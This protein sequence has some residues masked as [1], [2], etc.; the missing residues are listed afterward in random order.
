MPASQ[1]L[2]VITSSLLW[3]KSPHNMATRRHAHIAGVTSPRVLINVADFC[4]GNFVI[5]IFYRMTQRVQVRYR[6]HRL[7][8]VFLVYWWTA[9]SVIK[10]LARFPNNLTRL[11]FRIC[12]I[13]CM[14]ICIVF[15]HGYFSHVQ[16][17]I[18]KNWKR[19]GGGRQCISPVVIFCKCTQRTMYAVSKNDFIF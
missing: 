3:V 15:F 6:L 1:I 10:S 19:G 4:V 11:L 17:R 16:W 8:S 5:S 7:L 9:W 13:L 14:I 18:Q 12:H 2:S